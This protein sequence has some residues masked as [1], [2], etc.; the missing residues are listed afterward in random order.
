[1]SQKKQLR[2]ELDQSEKKFRTV[3]ETATDSIIIADQNS[4]IIF[5]NSK[6]FEV[7]GYTSEELLG[8]PLYR[9]MPYKYHE[10][11]LKGIERFLKTGTP[12][13]IGHIIEI[14]G[15]KKDGT[16]FPI[17]L[18]LSYWKED[19]TFFFTGII[20]DITQRKK[21]EQVL[22]QSEERFRLL[23]EDSTDI[24]SVHKLDSTI[25]YISPYCETVLGYKPIELIGKI[26]YDYYHPEDLKKMQGSYNTLSELPDVYTATFR[27]RK[28]NGSYIWFESTGRTIR[29]NKG[30]PLEIHAT[31]RDINQ[32]KEGEEL[33]R[34]SQERFKLLIEAVKDYA[35]FMLDPQGYIISW[36]EGAK[37]LKGYSEEEII[38]KHFSI[39][40]KKELVEKKYPEHELELAKKNGRYQ[41][42]GWRL[43]KDGSSFFADVTIT[44]LYDPNNKQLIGF[45]KITRDLTEKKQVEEKLHKLNSELEHRVTQRTKEL[46]KNIQE[47]KKTNNDLDNFIYTASHDLKA[48]ISNIEGL[49]YTLTDAIHDLN[50][51]NRNELEQ[52]IQL[53]SASILRLKGTIMDLTEITKIQKE[54]LEDVSDVNCEEIIDEVKLSIDQLILEA[55]VSLYKDIECCPKIHFSKKNFRS[56]IYNLLS[57][58]V[59]YR[60][61]DRKPEIHI[62]TQKLN[63]Y[64]LLT[65]KDNGLGIDLNR[66]KDKMF[67]MFKRF[68]DHVEGTGIGLYLVKRMMDNG[69]GKIEVESEVGK[70]TVFKLFFKAQNEAGK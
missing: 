38:G 31:N 37:R 8:Q 20:R 65:V 30:E 70:G 27:F 2:K 58:A 24:I 54:S 61:P 6:V 56:I 16:I 13:I 11:H 26:A 46:S 48:P 28:K 50:H 43:R 1:M 66:Y 3:A 36:N 7:F 32:R 41:E 55:N 17:E 10:A 53:M 57:N 18:S 22:K 34:R 4:H 47:L 59:K 23:A 29:N 60:A 14:E 62:Q 51:L 63:G 9:I 45:S 5:S 49:I 64:I 15:Q 21:E 12:K 68:H 44:A 52:I 25:L 42:L 19:K 69:E 33:L 40:Y 67:S 35:I 39:F